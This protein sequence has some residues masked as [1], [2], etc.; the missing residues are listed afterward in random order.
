MS[1]DIRRRPTA[2]KRR[3][4]AVI[5]PYCGREH[6]PSFD[7]VLHHT[8]GI[9]L[10]RL[11]QL[12]EQPNNDWSATP[13]FVTGRNDGMGAYALAPTH[14]RWRTNAPATFDWTF[15]GLIDKSLL[16]AVW[17][18]RRGAGQGGSAFDAHLTNQH[19]EVWGPII[20]DDI[21]TGTQGRIDDARAAFDISIRR[22]E[23]P[24]GYVMPH[25]AITYLGG[26]ESE[27]VAHFKDSVP[28]ERGDRGDTPNPP[29]RVT[30]QHMN[31]GQ[32]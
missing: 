8:K 29:R 16:P 3:W 31:G 18:Y 5:A 21:L 30:R 14:R 25:M 24:D 27:F 4:N 28:A 1:R 19:A 7:C 17:F 15:E 20:K 13:G 22:Q 12:S 23:A 6:H 32:S 10:E 26:P 2:P 11:K 9:E